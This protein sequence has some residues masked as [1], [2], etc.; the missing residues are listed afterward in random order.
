MRW[1]RRFKSGDFDLED[2]E[3]P[4]HLKKFQ[5]VKMQALLVQGD[6]QTQLLMA[7]MLN[8]GRHTIWECLHGM[9]KIQKAGK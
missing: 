4:G 7:E 1:F 2:K 8:V 5:Y 6:P 9:G 3:H